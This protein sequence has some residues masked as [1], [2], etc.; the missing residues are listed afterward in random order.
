MNVVEHGRVMYKSQNRNR[1]SRM[2][3]GW[4]KIDC[5][6]LHKQIVL[7]MY[8]VCRNILLICHFGVNVRCKSRMYVRMY[9][10]TLRQGVF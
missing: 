3:R 9:E 7:R 2:K 10:T 1:I 4:R 8:R 5:N 6:D